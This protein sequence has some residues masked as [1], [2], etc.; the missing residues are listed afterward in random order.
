MTRKRV[1]TFKDLKHFIKRQTSCQCGAWWSLLP[2][3]CSAKVETIEEPTAFLTNWFAKDGVGGS[4]EKV[5]MTRKQVITS[6]WRVNMS[7][8]LVCFLREFYV[9]R[10][11][12]APCHHHPSHVSISLML[13][14]YHSSTLWLFVGFILVITADWHS[15]INHIECDIQVHRLE[16]SRRRL[17]VFMMNSTLIKSPSAFSLSFYSCFCLSVTHHVN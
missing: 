7:Q 13:L 14:S 3:K 17:S 9:S 8:L 10:Q 15:L 4:V 11:K 1:I 16:W 12:M 2:A 6:L 5:L